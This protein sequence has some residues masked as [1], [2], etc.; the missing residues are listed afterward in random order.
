MRNGA[1]PEGARVLTR[2]S[3]TPESEH[4]R[5]LT[6][7]GTISPGWGIALVVFIVVAVG[8]REIRSYRYSGCRLVPEPGPFDSFDRP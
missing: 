7:G 1:Q 8:V 2:L 5:S 3:G 4:R 6:A